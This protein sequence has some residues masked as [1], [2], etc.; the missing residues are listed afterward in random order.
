M[1]RSWSCAISNFQLGLAA[2]CVTSPSDVDLDVVEDRPVVGEHGCRVDV[3]R[4]VG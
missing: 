3:S 2:V 4:R 1:S